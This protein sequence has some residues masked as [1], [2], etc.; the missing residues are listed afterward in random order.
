MA[1]SLRVTLLSLDMLWSHL[2]V[3]VG[4]ED[5][6]VEMILCYDYSNIQDG[7]EWVKRGLGWHSAA[8]G[9]IIIPPAADTHIS[10]LGNMLTLSN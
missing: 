9:I 5:D 10:V 4:S 3:V 6:T 2:P 1:F 7:W 8:G